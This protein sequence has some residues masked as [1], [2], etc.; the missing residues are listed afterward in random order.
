M[1]FRV[2]CATYE[3][4][5]VDEKGEEIPGP[6]LKSISRAVAAECHIACRWMSI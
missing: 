1:E 3:S 6:P 2:Q 4:F 5:A